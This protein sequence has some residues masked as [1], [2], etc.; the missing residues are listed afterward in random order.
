MEFCSKYGY[1]YGFDGSDEELLS[2]EDELT[3]EHVKRTLRKAD[4]NVIALKLDSLLEP[5]KMVKCQPIVCGKCTAYLS[6]LSQTKIKESTWECEYCD[7]LNDISNQYQYLNEF[8]NDDDITLNEE[9][10]SI[11]IKPHRDSNLIFCIDVSGSMKGSRL[12]GVQNSCVQ[13]LNHLLTNEPNK[14]VALVT[15]SN[16]AKY[17]G[18]T[19][20]LKDDPKKPIL[21]INPTKDEAKFDEQIKKIIRCGQAFSE[22]DLATVEKSFETLKNQILNLV[23]DGQTALGPALLF[24]IALSSRKPGS[25]IILCTDGYANIG[26]GSI[27]EKV[28]KF[29][30]NLADYALKKGITVNVV[31]FEG[32][33][34]KLA[35]LGRVAFKTNGTLKIVN[36]L[37][38]DEEF[39]SIVSNF[40]FA[41]NVE[42][43]LIVN[44]KYLYIRN[45]EIEE[46]ESKG[47]D[48]EAL[49]KSV[50]MRRIGNANSSTEITFEYGFKR[51]NEPN[52]SPDDIKALPFQLQISYVDNFGK[53]GLRIISRM[54]EFTRDREIAEKNVTSEELLCI[55]AAQKMSSQVLKSN[56]SLAKLRKLTQESLFARNSL[57][58]TEEYEKTTSII[59][60][61]S[62]ETQA[63][64]MS[65]Q[66]SANM[67]MSARMSTK[68]SCISHSFERSQ[69]GS[70]TRDTLETFVYGTSWDP[71][72]KFISNKP[73]CWGCYAKKC[74]C[75]A[76]IKPEETITSASRLQVA[77][78]KQS[79]QISFQKNQLQQRF[80]AK[81]TT[82]SS[83]A[84]L[85][86]S[87]SL[88]ETCSTASTSSDSY[89]KVIDEK[90]FNKVKDNLF[91][92]CDKEYTANQSQDADDESSNDGTSDD[93]KNE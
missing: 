15:F 26:I 88:D 50:D 80:S 41:T 36:P 59:Q 39:K 89:F 43:K 68:G 19:T 49:K 10:A 78:P 87:F 53:Y 75:C 93:E 79:I 5:F 55:N 77:T 52:V 9:S 69:T 22:H 56:V 81:S 90:S 28:E 8:I 74:I 62:N 73:T 92:L 37:T 29:Y 33:D 76:T 34:C 14:K 86:V 2:D 38:L 91:V 35:L 60:K 20:N 6:P 21:M 4:T 42:V 67:F 31:S 30:D 23:A 7:E 63:S 3:H 64:Q 45:E 58:K 66:L 18:D 27:N 25:S 83:N 46:A 61:L 17:Y 57:K 24:S 47:A 16:R 11:D 70:I 82:N 54:Q 65:D 40:N 72:K 32:S 13:T 51:I 12:K 44:Y 84:D 1:N 48:V 71:N 85:G